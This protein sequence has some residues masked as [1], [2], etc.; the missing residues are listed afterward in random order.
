MAYEH[1]ARAIGTNIM[2][3]VGSVP[4]QACI[5]VM[6]YCILRAMH[7]QPPLLAFCSVLA[8]VNMLIALPV[9][10]SG[11][12]VREGLFIMFF[13]LFHID[14]EHAVAFS[15]TFFCAESDLEHGWAAPF[16]FLYR[17]ETHLPPPDVTE[18][19]PIFSER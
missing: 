8:I 17:H 19:E 18:V 5:T 11:L 12:G 6:G 10:I 15:L 4:S 3:L 7:L 1:T 14:K 13:A 9:S 2:A 16:Y